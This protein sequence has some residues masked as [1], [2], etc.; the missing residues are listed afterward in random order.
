[1][2]TKQKLVIS[3]VGN[4]DGE[5]HDTMEIL[6]S[7]EVVNGNGGID[8]SK[9]EGGSAKPEGQMEEYTLSWYV[10]GGSVLVLGAFLGY[11]LGFISH[12]RKKLGSNSDFTALKT[13]ET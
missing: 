1:V 8:S 7:G 4:H 12:S 3:Y 6:G 2:A 9:L 5:V 11:I 10:Q 13:E